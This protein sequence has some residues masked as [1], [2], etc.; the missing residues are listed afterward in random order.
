MV[1]VTEGTLPRTTRLT[2]ENNAPID[3]L[4]TGGRGGLVVVPG[5]KSYH[6]VLPGDHLWASGAEQNLPVD[7][8]IGRVEKVEASTDPKDAH[9]V[10]LY[11]RPHENVSSI[12]D[13]F[14]ISPVAPVRERR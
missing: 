3:V 10:K 14:I 13:V 9:R 8:Y 6:N 12:R 1:T 4:V 11:V 2:D 5:V 7:I